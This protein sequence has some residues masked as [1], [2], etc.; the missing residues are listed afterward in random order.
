MTDPASTGHSSPVTQLSPPKVLPQPGPRTA[1]LPAEPVDLPSFE[2]IYE[3]QFAFVW[4]SLRRLGVATSAAED[5]AQ[6]VFLAIHRRLADFEGRSS[7][8]TWVFGFVL[9]VA[10]DHRRRETRKGGA[11][12]LP[13][14]LVDGAPDPLEHLERSEGLALLDEVLATLD[15]ERRAVLVMGDIEEMTA[16]EIAEV[17]GVSPNIVYSKLRLARRDLEREIERRK[18]DGK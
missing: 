18:G 15:E 4:R 2:A 7:V 17:L 11:D 5:A 13:P 3:S 16:P 6:D 1:T 8:R 10:R 14:G 9:R 12:P